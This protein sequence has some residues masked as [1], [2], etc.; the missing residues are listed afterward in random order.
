MIWKVILFK[1]F[2][3]RLVTNLW[4]LFKDVCGTEG[5]ISQLETELFVSNGSGTRAEGKNFNV[6]MIDLLWGS[7][8]AKE[9]VCWR[10]WN[11]NVV[12]SNT[13]CLDT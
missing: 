11:D 12:S 9:D 3:L 8:L 7:S 5:D 10:D 4:W 6:P 1:G 13:T 2:S